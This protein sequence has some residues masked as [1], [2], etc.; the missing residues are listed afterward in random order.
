MG[1]IGPQKSAN[2]IKPIPSSASTAFRR[3]G[4]VSDVDIMKRDIADKDTQIAHL[5]KQAAD[6]AEISHALQQLIFDL[7]R[8]TGEEFFSAEE[9]SADPAA[10]VHEILGTSRAALTALL[11]LHHG[12]EDRYAAHFADR[13][14]SII[15]EME[16][17]RAQIEESR[18]SRAQ[19]AE[20]TKRLLRL[21]AIQQAEKGSLLSTLHSLSKNGSSSR[22]QQEHEDLVVR[23]RMTTVR[24]SMKEVQ[25]SVDAKQG[26]Y[27]ELERRALSTGQRRMLESMKDDIA[28]NRRIAGL[29]KRLNHEKWENDLSS[30]EL[31]HVT[32][33]IQRAEAMIE[34]FKAS[35]T[36]QQQISADNVNMSLRFF[37]ENQ[38][39][40]FKRAIMNQRRRNTELERQR[41]ELTEEE[42]M[43]AG[44]LQTVE[45][46]LQAQMQK[47]PSIAQL[48]HQ[49]FEFDRPRK[50]TTVKQ[51][52]V[53]EDAEMRGIRKA[54]I[55][56][57]SRK[58]AKSAMVGSR[59]T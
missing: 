7:E 18:E 58:A 57:K 40:D 29:Q 51:K 48:Q 14:Q 27:S 23:A 20:Q 19:I 46:Q 4:V 45:K 13:A 52:R 1:E 11:D 10:V 32:C 17:K 50:T 35:L 49:L 28:L 42:K 34:R 39:E 30:Q 54:I 9:R 53:P 25:T 24:A 44:F 41:T 15:S 3:V 6:V 37:I 59:Y 12:L 56:V 8:S 36:K 21:K 38:R 55:A 31:V 26:K 22:Q 5:N 2:F 43:L 33:E 16:S 47:L